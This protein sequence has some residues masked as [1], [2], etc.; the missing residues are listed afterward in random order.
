MPKDITTS[1]EPRKRNA[2]NKSQSMLDRSSPGAWEA[3][4]LSTSPAPTI[5]DGK[6]LRILGDSIG[7][8]TARICG[9]FNRSDEEAADVQDENDVEDILCGE[10]LTSHAEINPQGLLATI[11]RQKH[12]LQL[13][14][15]SF[16]HMEGEQ[17][18]L[19]ERLAELEEELEEK[20]CTIET[21]RENKLQYRA[22]WLNEI[23]FTKYLL[24]K[25]PE[26]NRDVNWVG[27]TR[28]RYAGDH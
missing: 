15:N 7:S 26:L 14:N 10:S 19:K 2:R 18:L 22:W 11:K 21:L 1:R 16:W 4:S 6:G 27:K 17:K 5:R 3:P 13:R 23:R 25:E 12:Q 20:D 8:D 9:T 24:N 28:T